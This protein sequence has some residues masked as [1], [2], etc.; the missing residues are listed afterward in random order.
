MQ[1][2]TWGPFIFLHPTAPLA[3][4]A[5]PVADWLG[6]AAPVMEAA[7]MADARLQHV[8]S[9][10]Y[11]LAC[12]WKVFSDN[13][14]DG[15][16]HVAIAHPDL[17]DGID[18][19]SYAHSIYER[20][21]IQTA[22]TRPGSSSNTGDDRLG[23]QEVSY[24]F[25]YPN[26]MINRYGPWM[27]TNVVVPLAPDRCRVDFDWWI[28]QDL[29]LDAGIIDAGV[30]SSDQVQQEDIK[31]CEGVQRGLDS[32]A[33]NVGRY[34]PKFE[35]PMFHFHRLLHAAMNNTDR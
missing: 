20:V 16:Y 2:D 18:M 34:V 29:A 25:V 31:L 26:L 19:A 10:S 22:R 24:A 21:S 8:R 28:D 15:G 5:Q 7:G 32:P 6:G 27:D 11:E 33:Y 1:L 35:A 30:Q 14:L 9:R 3:R 4:P 17:A 13:Y 12:N 23:S